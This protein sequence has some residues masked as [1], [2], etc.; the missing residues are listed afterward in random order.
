MV[1]DVNALVSN[2]SR[3]RSW[4]RGG[5]R[6]ARSDSKYILPRKPLVAL[7]VTSTV[8]KISKSRHS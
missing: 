2:Q 1:E 8:T 3:D 4:T 6:I 7:V 5:N